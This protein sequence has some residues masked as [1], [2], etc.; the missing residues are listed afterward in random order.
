MESKKT[1]HSAFGKR[2]LIL[3][4]VVF[5]AVCAMYLVNHF[6]YSSPASVVEVSVIDENSNKTVLKTF[7]LSENT[8]YT[9]VTSP[10][11]AG[12]AE[13]I[14]HLII[15]DGAAWISEANCPNHDCV[16]N[17]KISQS[18]E[19]LVC[20]PHRLTVTILGE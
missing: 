14:N 9:I 18:G 1:T 7:S 4:A 5:V 19:I 13:G 17:G 20:L 16:K 11:S 2:E 6:R 12:D 8:E 15:R 10:T 3:L